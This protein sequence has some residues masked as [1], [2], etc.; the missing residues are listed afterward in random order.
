MR[1]LQASG[2]FVAEPVAL[3]LA[4]TRPAIDGKLV[5]GLPQFR[6]V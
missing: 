6:Y 5:E 4:A 1:A 3:F 2:V